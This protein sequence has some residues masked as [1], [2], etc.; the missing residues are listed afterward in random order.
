MRGDRSP[1]FALYALADRLHKT[2]AELGHMTAEE[3]AGWQAYL[4]VLQEKES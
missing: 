4:L 3:F 2:V 1:E